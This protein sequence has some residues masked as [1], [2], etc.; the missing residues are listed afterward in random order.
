MRE[1]PAILAAL[2]AA[3]GEPAALATL[4]HVEGSSYR[5]PGARL[6]LLA[7]GTRLGSISGGC[8]EDDVVLR[9]QRVL[10]S[11][12]PEVAIYDTTEENDLVWGVGLGCRGVVHIFIE[13]LPVA[14][15]AWIGELRQNLQAR[16]STTLAVVHGG[17]HA[18]GQGTRLL[19]E[20]PAGE[21]TSDVF[22]ETVGAPPPLVVF[23]AGEDAL[24]LVR[25]AKEIGW[26]VT[27][28]DSRA[29]YATTAR[30]PE[31]DS[32][33][34]TAADAVSQ[35]PLDAGT[36]AVVLTHRYSEDVKLLRALL[37][38]TLAYLGV[39]GPRKRTDRILTELKANGFTPDTAMLARLHA[40]VGLDLGATTPE[41]V[42]LAIL[43]E[44]Q[45]RLG[46]RTPIHLRDRPGPIHG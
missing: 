33:I 11:G 22:R 6:L 26:H 35:M 1:I 42:A 7:N 29:G 17:R 25:L 20:L 4:V 37:P 32:V 23:G 46:N 36:F 41:G 38:K 45:S 28:V 15:P 16:R 24:P 12:Q 44:L 34:V 9:A 43:A 3:P 19:G 5:R 39:L 14:R 2:A 30:F 8:L 13:P 18:I 40:P 27:V 21:I 10:A 31:A